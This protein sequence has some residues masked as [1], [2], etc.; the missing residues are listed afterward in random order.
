MCLPLAKLYLLAVS[1]LGDHRCH[2][3][4]LHAKHAQRAHFCHAALPLYLPCVQADRLLRVVAAMLHHSVLK[5]ADEL[6]GPYAT[7]LNR[8]V[9]QVLLAG[10]ARQQHLA[11]AGLNA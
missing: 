9:N 1:R 4:F 8:L 7:A 6:T 10:T 3:P 5:E 11:E 2:A